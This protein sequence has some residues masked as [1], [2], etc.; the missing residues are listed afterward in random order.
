MSLIGLCPEC[1]KRLTTD[2]KDHSEIDWQDMDVTV[3]YEI[4]CPKCRAVV[5]ATVLF[6][7]GDATT[8]DLKVLKKGETLGK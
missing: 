6:S 7:I 8:M 1:G 4:D 3:Y 2:L 5:E